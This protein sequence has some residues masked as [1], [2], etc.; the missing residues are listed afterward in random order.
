MSGLATPLTSLIGRKR[1]ITQLAD[2]LA[3]ARLVTLTGPGGVGKTSLALQL[4]AD[5][6]ERFPDGVTFVQLAPV[7]DSALVLPTI[8]AALGI[9]LQSSQ[10]VGAALA[11]ALHDQHLLLLLDNFEH[12]SSA[13]VAIG[14]LLSACPRLTVLATSRTPLNLRREHR[15][16]VRPLALPDTRH[17]TQTGD[18]ARVPAIQLFVERA[19]AVQPDLVLTSDSLLTIAV[20]C[21]RLDGLPLA[22]EL[23]AARTAVL[24]PDAVLT[25]LGQQA[26]VLTSRSVDLPERHRT[27]RSTIAWSY[28]L[29]NSSEQA[30]FRQLSVFSGGWTLESAETVCVVDGDLLEC[31]TTLVEASLVRQELTSDEPRFGMLETIR[32][33]AL[34]LLEQQG[35][36][37]FARDRHADACVRLAEVA[38]PQLAGNQQRAWSQRLGAELGNLRAALAWLRERADA[39]RALRLLGQVGAFIADRAGYT[40][41]L[42]LFRWFL[43]LPADNPASAERA[44]ALA[45]AGWMATFHGDHAAS[46]AFSEQAWSLC[47]QL[48]DP[49]LTPFLCVSLG[50]ATCLSGDE[51]R[52]DAYWEEAVRLGHELD[53]ARSMARALNNLGST[54]RGRGEFEGA[55]ARFEEALAVARAAQDQSSEALVL[56]NLGHS[57]LTQDDIERAE[58]VLQHSLQLFREQD[59][60][61]WGLM[62]CVETLAEVARRRGRATHA[63]LLFSAGQALHTRFNIADEGD[64]G[65]ERRDTLRTLRARLGDDA[66]ASAWS[67]GQAMTR[68]DLIVEITEMATG[69]GEH[70][71]P[72]ELPLPPQTHGLSPRELEVLRLLVEG[73]SDREIAT[74]LFISHH[75][76]MRH[77]SNILGKLAVESRTAAATYA[78]RHHLI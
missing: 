29:L 15:Y 14:A 63:V 27:L 26:E 16:P 21:R 37:E 1:E 72:A 9:Q 58:D 56:L 57:A 64:F 74:A 68:D 3:S 49:T 7:R 54:A 42:A 78:V 62:S 47:Q 45:V 48:G 73:Q 43:G 53:D 76:V 18:L 50:M 44:R 8:A 34:E 23:A 11:S 17:L 60:E 41:G 10:P 32:D 36:A 5:V 59:D 2:L 51:A 46:I 38:G 25:R 67:R 30:L 35:E 65:T 71:A 70:G 6:A 66:Y 55:A 22:I 33:Y 19:R 40:E 52:G 39:E 75:T 13:A 61:S 77:V 12:V 31:L 20:L 69:A 4:A 28:D 24:S